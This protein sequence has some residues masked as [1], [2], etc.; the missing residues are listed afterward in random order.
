MDM[1]TTGG[2]IRRQGKRS[3]GNVFFYIYKHEITSQDGLQN[4]NEETCDNNID[5]N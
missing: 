5:H 2:N 3:F 1:Y 4:V